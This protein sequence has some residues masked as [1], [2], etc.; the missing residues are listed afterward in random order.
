MI[1][2]PTFKGLT[3]NVRGLSE[4]KFLS[5]VDCFHRESLDFC[6]V[7]ETI[8]DK[9]VM[10]S[11]CSCWRGSIYWS[12]AVGRRGGVA[13]FLAEELKNKVI[14]WRKDA[15]GRVLSILVNFNSVRINLINVYAPTV[16]AE[17]APFFQSVHSF[18]FSHSEYVV[19][20]DFHCY[21]SL[22]DKFGGNV[23]VSPVLS[24]FK[25]CFSRDA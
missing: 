15:D 7:L 1:L 11:F 10:N 3:I 18:F 9:R 5:V 19:G 14:C 24:D 13:I 2:F 4:I 25:S 22:S 12:T 21:D 20:G 6:F 8:S 16:P 23:S 17:R